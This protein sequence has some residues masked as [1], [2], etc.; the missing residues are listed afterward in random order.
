LLRIANTDGYPLLLNPDWERDLGYSREEL[1]GKQIFD[2][3]HSE[4]LNKTRQAFS[5]MAS[6]KS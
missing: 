6:E 1:T 4:D 2:F 3:V 5:T